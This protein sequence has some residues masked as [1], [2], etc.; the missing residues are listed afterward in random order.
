MQRRTNI[1]VSSLII[2]LS[3][4]TII[5]Q[6]VTYYFISSFSMIWGISCLISLLCCHLLVQQ[7]TS[8]EAC[9]NFSFLTLFI[10]IIVIG[11]TYLGKGQSFLPYTATMLGL[12]V[13]NWLVPSIYCFLRYMLDSGAQ[14]VDFNAFYRNNSIVFFLFYIGVIIYGS[15]SASAFPWAYRAVIGS[16]NII[17]F[18]IIAS[19]IEDYLYE[20][21]PL[22]DIITYLLSRIL[23][24]I[25]YGYFLALILRR[26]TRLTRFFTLLLL[27]CVLEALQ[28][29]IIPARCD[30]DDILYAFIGGIIGSLS[31]YLL[32]IVFHAFTGKD[33][34][35][36]DADFHFSNSTLHF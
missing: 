30:I 3:I 9:F 1:Q 26:Q 20:I 22:S 27:P 13:I 4:L 6:F 21:I 29:F 12:A 31:Y 23:I 25:P 36:K 16:S 14:I 15:F 2:I 19:Q 34:L 32:N 5:V 33:F 8:Y 11:L 35:T 18:D 17:P 28:Y 10:S 7:T 24:F